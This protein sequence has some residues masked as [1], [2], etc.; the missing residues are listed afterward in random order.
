LIWTLVGHGRGV[1]ELACQFK[2][3]EYPFYCP[4]CELNYCSKDWDTYVLFDEGFYD[5]TMGTCPNGH[6][7]TLDD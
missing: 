4:D 7:H 6:Q 3:D 2:R 1:D 5:C